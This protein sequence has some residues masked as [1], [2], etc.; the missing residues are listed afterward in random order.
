MSLVHF[1][2]RPVHTIESSCSIAEAA[3]RMCH[4]SVGALVI[5]TIRH[6]AP[7][8]IITDRDIVT[9]VAEGLNPRE[10]TV[11]RFVRD[12]LHTILVTDSLSDALAKM[13]KHGVRRL[14]IVDAE[15]GLCGIVSLDDILV[16]LGKELADV[17]ATVTGEIEHER[18]LKQRL[19]QGQERIQ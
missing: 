8:G 3:R 4:Y 11:G 12:P 13:R 7:L 18:N 9:L 2:Q 17:A 15:G 10:T 16:W 1:T 6:P 14:P 5:V 19:Q